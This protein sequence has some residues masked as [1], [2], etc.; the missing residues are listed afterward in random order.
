MDLTGTLAISGSAL[1]AERLRLDTIA[2]NLANA[3]TT[4]TPE[5]G[6][7]R[8]RNV[9]FA[10]EPLENDFGETLA[11]LAEQ[12]AHEGVTVTDVVEDRTPPRMVFDPSHPDANADGYVAY[13]NVDPMA[14]TIDLMAATRA[15]EANVQVVNATRRMAEAALGIGG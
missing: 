13:P 10:A 3:S 4:R 9:V 2:S 1:S 8:R 12:G 15:Y 14:E 7:Y 5:G 11:S 6:P